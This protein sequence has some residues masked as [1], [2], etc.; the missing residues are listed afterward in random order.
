M[1]QM[2][3]GGNVPIAASAL[4]ATLLWSGG[5]G[6]PDVDASALLLSADGK[7]SSDADFVYYNQPQHAS[8]A[9]RHLGKSSAAQFS[10]AIEIDLAQ[11]PPGFERIVLAASAD[12]GTFG[13]V[14]G[15][16]LLLAD[17]WLALAGVAWLV[18]FALGVH[19]A[20]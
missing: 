11:V 8:G 16:E 1:T 10:D 3:K 14:P 18:L 6:V 15:L 17:R 19:A 12:G 20:D 2:T 13:Q 7:V 4:R 5:A 9:V